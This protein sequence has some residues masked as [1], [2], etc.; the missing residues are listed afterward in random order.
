M[1]SFCFAFIFYFEDAPFKKKIYYI[2]YMITLSLSPDTP[3]EG[4]GSLLQMVVSHHVVAGIRTQ[5]LW[6]SSQC[7]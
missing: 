6:K 4:I 5:D 2:M 1:L 7:F 3:E